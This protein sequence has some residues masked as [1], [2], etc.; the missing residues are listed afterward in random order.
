MDRSGYQ[1]LVDQLIGKVEGLCDVTVRKAVYNRRSKALFLTTD[2]KYKGLDK[3]KFKLAEGDEET[4]MGYIKEMEENPK[5]YIMTA[6][7]TMLNYWLLN[8]QRRKKRIFDPRYEDQL[9]LLSN[10]LTDENVSVYD[11][12]KAL[13]RKGRYRIPLTTRIK[14]GIVEPY[15]VIKGLTKRGDR[16]R[17]RKKGLIARPDKMI[18]IEVKP[19]DSEFIEKVRSTNPVDIGRDILSRA[20]NKDEQRKIEDESK[21]LAKD[22]YRREEEEKVNRYIS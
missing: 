19:V 14:R 20:D 4:L 13:E 10:L 18:R 1:A 21:R 5:G 15:Y 17:I 12:G 8:Q 2:S 3:L 22:L 9:N 11:F 7:A 16:P 6:K